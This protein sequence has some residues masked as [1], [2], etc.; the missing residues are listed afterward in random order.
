MRKVLD[1]DRLAARHRPPGPPVMHQEWGK[2][3]F[4][5]WRINPILLR[6]HIPASLEID[7][8]GNSAWIAIAPFTMWDIRG[9]PPFLPAVPVFRDDRFALLD[10]PY[11]VSMRCTN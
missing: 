10:H 2:L 1:V 11:P 5:H 8:Y 4:I 9:L 3:L 6:P 7:T